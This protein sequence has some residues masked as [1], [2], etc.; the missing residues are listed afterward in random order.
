MSEYESEAMIL[1]ELDQARMANAVMYAALKSIE[2][3]MALIATSE[4]CRD[5]AAG[6]VRGALDFA[7]KKGFGVEVAQ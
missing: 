2:S 7:A 1:D 5:I 6:V 3:N 4:E